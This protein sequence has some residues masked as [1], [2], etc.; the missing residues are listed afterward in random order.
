MIAPA[1]LLT[2]IKAEPFRP[3]QFHVASGKTFDIR[4]PETVKVGKTFLLFFSLA[5]GETEV[6]DQW[7]SVSLMLIESI[8]H[9]DVAVGT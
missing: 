2:Y 7:E 3:F 6:V 1:Q 4:H 5:E 8:S 9:L